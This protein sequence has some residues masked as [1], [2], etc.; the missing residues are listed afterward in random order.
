[1]HYTSKQNQD[2]RGLINYAKE[3]K[4][5]S[6]NSDSGDGGLTE[7]SLA[8]ARLRLN[9]LKTISCNTTRMIFLIRKSNY[10]I[11]QEFTTTGVTTC[12][13]GT[14]KKEIWGGSS[15]EEC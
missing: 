15:L 14:L 7:N 1:M 12:L 13:L 10:V 11:T 9:T 4:L 8:E 6:S 3:F 5:Y 2:H